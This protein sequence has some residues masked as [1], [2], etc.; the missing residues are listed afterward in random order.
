MRTSRLVNLGRTFGRARVPS[1]NLAQ[2]IDTPYS[3]PYAPP[4]V[5]P[6]IPAEATIT[7][8]AVDDGVPLIIDDAMTFL[9]P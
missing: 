9:V 7:V 3:D 1:K 6:D 5:N 8:L 2:T 4:E